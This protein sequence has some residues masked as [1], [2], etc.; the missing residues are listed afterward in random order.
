MAMDG[1]RFLWAPNEA[2]E[3]PPHAFAAH[4]PGETSAALTPGGG[5][6]GVAGGQLPRDL[7]IIDSVDGQLSLPESSTADG[8]A[9]AA[10][11]D[12]TLAE[13]ALG[14]FGSGSPVRL[15]GFKADVCTGCCPSVPGFS[16]SARVVGG[17]AGDAGDLPPV[18]DLPDPVVVPYSAGHAVE[19]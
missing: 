1:H 15:Y 16:S 6:A 13:S 19:V 4:T 14:S 17:V 7:S 5:G 8:E 2:D 10:A 9:L 12:G 3:A 18:W 11:A